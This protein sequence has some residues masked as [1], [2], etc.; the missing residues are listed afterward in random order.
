MK[1][2]IKILFVFILLLSEGSFGPVVAIGELYVGLK[3]EHSSVLQFEPAVAFI[4]I[5]NDSEIPFVLDED[6]L[7]NNTHVSFM[8][9]RKPDKPVARINTEPFI[10]KLK[11]MPN[12]TREILVD[13]SLLYDIGSEG[14][15]IVAAKIDWHGKMFESN[16]A[17]ID[18]VRGIEIATVSKN[19]PGYPEL[20]RKYSLRYW[21]RDNSEYL[22]LCVDEE[23]IGTNY[24]VFK[25]GRL[26]RVF[27][28]VIEVDR[29]GNVKVL[30]QSER[31]CYTRSIF[32]SSLAGVQFIDQTY[33]LPDGEPYLFGGSE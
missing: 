2:C 4:S 27:K 31:N 7:D 21:G 23:E 10:R 33:H 30:H 1:R 14:R 29:A 16:K 28:P 17:V 26:V 32:K 25:L 22:F 3:L 6:A 8:I 20:I 15:Y 13:I 19:V 9:E 24:G 11:L 5:Y 18:I 12:E